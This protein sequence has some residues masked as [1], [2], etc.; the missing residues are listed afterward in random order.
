M[1][2]ASRRA[3][4]ASGSSQ[5]LEALSG[6]SIWSAYGPHEASARLATAGPG[7]VAASRPN[8]RLVLLPVLLL[9]LA[10]PIAMGYDLQVV[11]LNAFGFGW[12]GWLV[13]R[14]L[15]DRLLAAARGGH[16]R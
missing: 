3:A 10:A 2:A 15:I 5:R 11:A 12:A 8:R 4:R 13:R 16:R 1:S 9:L 6:E 14:I 7:Q